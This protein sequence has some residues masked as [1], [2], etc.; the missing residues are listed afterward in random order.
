MWSLSTIFTN[1]ETA[2]K[3]IWRWVKFTFLTWASL[4]MALKCSS[5]LNTILKL[6]NLIFF[7]QN[8]LKHTYLF[9]NYLARRIRQPIIKHWIHTFKNLFNNQNKFY[10]SELFVCYCESKTTWMAKGQIISKGLFG[11][12][13]FSQ[14]TNERIRFFCLTAFCVAK[15]RLSTKSKFVRSFFGRKWRHHKTFWN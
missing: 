5:D 1:L 9:T 11:V 6:W 12:L 4:I 3:R 7:S 15:R 10:N 2:G 13:E 8:L 14:K